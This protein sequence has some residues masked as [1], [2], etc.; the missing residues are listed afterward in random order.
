MHILELT[1]SARKLT[2]LPYF[3]GN[4]MEHARAYFDQLNR[5][6]TAVHRTKED[7]FWSTYMAT[8]DDQ[9]GF[10][11]PGTPTKTSSPIR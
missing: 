2:N 3:D 6:Y 4:S 8:S 1:G 11:R 7:L 10:T 9:A 5:D